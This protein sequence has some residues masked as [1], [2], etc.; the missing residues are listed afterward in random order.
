M[1]YKVAVKELET[2]EM[3]YHTINIPVFQGLTCEK[4]ETLEFKVTQKKNKGGETLIEFPEN[5]VEDSLEITIEYKKVSADI[6]IKGLDQLIREPC[7]CFEQTSSTTF[8]LVMLIQ[9]IDS[10]PKKTEKMLKMRFNAEEKMKKGIKRL[11]GYECKN[12]GF[13]WFGD[14]PGHVTLT[15]YGIWQFLEMN[16]IGNY[17]DVNVIDRTLDWLRKSYQKNKAQFEL[18]NGWDDFASPPQF[19]SDIYI[20]FILTLMEDYQVNYHQ[21]VEHKIEDYESRKGSSKIDCY[22]SSFI[23][24]VYSGKKKSNS[25]FQEWEKTKRQKR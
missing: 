9:Y 5:L 2:Q 24:L 14:D 8:P 7:G 4:S 10:L 22:L 1:P 23:A 18:R 20:L 16:K 11:L 21:I 13:E 17:I 25:N 12:G 6:L 19:C 15:A 3:L